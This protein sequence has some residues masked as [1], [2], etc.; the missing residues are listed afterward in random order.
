M[1]GE[2]LGQLVNGPYFQLCHQFALP[3]AAIFEEVHPFF[4]VIS[5]MEQYD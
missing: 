3:Q 2:L 1:E 4:F 5:K